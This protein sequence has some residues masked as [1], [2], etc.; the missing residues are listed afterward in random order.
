MH[1]SG[2][3]LTLHFFTWLSVACVLAYLLFRGHRS[4]LLYLGATF[5]CVTLILLADGNT[6][7]DTTIRWAI[8]GI[9]V[10]TLIMAFVEGVS[11]MKER[12]QQLREEQRE[13]EMAFAD[14]QK[15]LVEREIREEGEQPSK[16]EP[17]A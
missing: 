11:D 10:F 9:A 13:R 17:P 4:Y 14:F 3:V 8:A 5:M 6:R 16:A 7:T 2:D 15:A 12:L 1:T